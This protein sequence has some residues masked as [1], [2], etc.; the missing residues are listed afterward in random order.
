[1]A[2]DHTDRDAIQQVL[3]LAVSALQAGG[4]QPQVKDRAYRALVSLWPSIYFRE[5]TENDA[6]NCNLVAQFA[7]KGK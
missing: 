5:F 7:K 4:Q 2:I 3:N 6:V 1:M